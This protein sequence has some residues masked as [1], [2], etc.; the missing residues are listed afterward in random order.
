MVLGET[1]ALQSLK[2]IVIVVVDVFFEEY[3]RKPN[4]KDIDRLLAHGECRDFPDMLGSIDHMRWKW[5][6]CPATWKSQYCGHIH[7]LT[8]ILEA[9]ASYDLWIWHAFFGFPESNNDINVLEQS[10]IYSE[11]AQGRTP[12]INYLINGH[13]YT[14]KYYLVDGIYPKWQHL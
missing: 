7:K 3:L 5:E 14:L 6:N 11:L 10:H 2:K 4:N 8:I 13:D 9:V 1:T 12:T